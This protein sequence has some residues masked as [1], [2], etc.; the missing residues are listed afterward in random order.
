MSI[1]LF[2][3]ADGEWSEAVPGTGGSTFVASEKNGLHMSDECFKMAL[4]DAISVS[5]KALGVAADVY[6]DK[7]STKYGPGEEHPGNRVP[8]PS[9]EA[10]LCEECGSR[11]A[12]YWD[13]EKLIKAAALAE[14]QRQRFGGAALCSKCGKRPNWPAK[15]HEAHLQQ[16]PMVRGQRGGLA[17][18]ADP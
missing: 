9:D 3:K 15:A 18:G 8:P 13:G 11:F 14:R 16:G 2:Y 6:W 12:D 7:D 5:A 10:I 17:G 1:D 4:T